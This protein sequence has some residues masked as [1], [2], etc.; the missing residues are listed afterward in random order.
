MEV[1]RKRDR[2][3]KEAVDSKVDN[4]FEALYCA[5]QLFGKDVFQNLKIRENNLKSYRYMGS[6]IT[7]FVFLSLYGIYRIKSFNSK[8]I[9]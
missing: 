5:P 3:K 1:D 6:L 7:G 4:F 9:L 8:L 2:L